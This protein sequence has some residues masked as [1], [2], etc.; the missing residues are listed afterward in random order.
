MKDIYENESGMIG[1]IDAIIKYIE[2]DENIDIYNYEEILHNLKVMR[3]E[4]GTE[5]IVYLSN[6][7][8]YNYSIDYWEESDKIK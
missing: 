4:N 3:E 2:N 8:D 1:N 6:Y 5:L 7:N